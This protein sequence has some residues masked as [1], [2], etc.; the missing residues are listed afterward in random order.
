M[1]R[2]KEIF[3]Y[4]SIPCFPNRPVLLAPYLKEV[5]LSNLRR[6]RQMRYVGARL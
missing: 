6:G 3:R 2:R 1:L 4:D 5:N